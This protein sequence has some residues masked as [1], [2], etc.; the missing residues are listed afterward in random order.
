MRVMLKTD[1]YNINVID[2]RNL[3]LT[4]SFLILLSVIIQ[5]VLIILAIL[6]IV[7]FLIILF[8]TIINHYLN[9]LV[10]KSTTIDCYNRNYL[11]KIFPKLLLKSEEEINYYFCLSDLDGLSEVN[12]K[13][14]YEIGDKWIS[15]YVEEAKKNLTK[16]D[17][18][19]RFQEGDEFMIVLRC[20]NISEAVQVCKNIQKKV[21]K[22][23]L[24]GVDT[25]ISVSIGISK[26][27]KKDN[28]LEDVA[29][30]AT[31]ALHEAKKIK[32]AVKT[33]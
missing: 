22:C 6:S 14:G 13:Y 20:S 29:N 9:Q 32:N 1:E 27:V 17:F 5:N 10:Y 28:C 25:P 15:C 16:N 24:K 33:N 23:K 18:F 2:N 26:L 19:A 30:R 12:N 7:Q 3:Y 4:G 21:S 11:N 8:Q 31:E